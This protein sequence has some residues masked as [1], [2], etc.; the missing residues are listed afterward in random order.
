MVKPPTPDPKRKDNIMGMSHLWWVEDDQF[1][2]ILDLYPD[3]KETIEANGVVQI[4]IPG[5]DKNDIAGK[6][7]VGRTLVTVTNSKGKVVLTEESDGRSISAELGLR[8]LYSSEYT[9]RVRISIGWGIR[10]ITRKEISSLKI[11]RKMLKVKVIQ[12]WLPLLF[13][14]LVV[15]VDC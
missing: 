14:Y 4:D 8:N 13:Q 3:Q 6:M 5:V 1:S 2:K 9:V 15:F 10:L 12:N 11:K 7:L